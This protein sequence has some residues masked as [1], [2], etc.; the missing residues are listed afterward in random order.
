MYVNNF[1]MEQFVFLYIRLEHGIQIAL[2]IIQE[3]FMIIFLGFC[4][5]SVMFF[6]VKFFYKERLKIKLDGDK[7][8]KE[9]S[10]SYLYQQKQDYLTYYKEFDPL[11]NHKK[12]LE[13]SDNVVVVNFVDHYKRLL[14]KNNIK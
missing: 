10:E 1:Y 8:S 6:L 2:Y 12:V 4:L 5:F 13:R 9:I 11:N 7:I 3:V 14:K